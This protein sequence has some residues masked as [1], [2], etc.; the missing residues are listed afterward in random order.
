M[1]SSG[2]MFTFC[3]AK[4]D[5][6]HPLRTRVCVSSQ[7]STVPDSA[8]RTTLH[9][10]QSSQT[11][12][13]SEATLV[14]TTDL[15]RENLKRWDSLH[16]PMT[17]SAT[18]T[19]KT[20]SSIATKD[21]DHKLEGW[22]ILINTGSIPEDLEKHIKNVVKKPG[23]D[24][25]ASAKQLGQLAE[26]LRNA[27]ESTVKT[28]LTGELLFKPE[29]QGGEKNI[30]VIEDVGFDRVWL[31]LAPGPNTEKQY[32]KL[33]QP[34]PDSAVGYIRV[35]AAENSRKQLSHPFSRDQERAFAGYS[36][37]RSKDNILFL[38]LT[39][40]TSYLIQRDVLFPFLTAQWKCQSGEGHYRAAQQAARDGATI[41]RNLDC[42]FTDANYPA[43]V[44]DTAHFSLTTDSDSVKLWVH[45]IDKD[46]AAAPLYRMRCIK[47]A[48]LQMH[49]DD[50]I[51]M[52][53]MRMMLLNILE[54]ANGERLDRIKDAITKLSSD[55]PARVGRTSTRV[56]QLSTGSPLKRAVSAQHV[57]NSSDVMDQDVIENSP[58][59]NAQ[60]SSTTSRSPSQKSKRQK[61]TK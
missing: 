22:N 46:S 2:T 16:P 39:Q 35:T 42:F 8:L 53:D 1:T 45:W 27:S 43:T 34:R 3:P 29:A 57:G 7:K 9:P 51:G 50:D 13:D 60:T 10:S 14:V 24:T 15:T 32:G 37:F 25:T 19:E 48:F 59:L 41:S 61:I 26:T 20:Q 49:D 11:S 40:F 56:S 21:T 28:T 31:P 12:G 17:G 18:A 54:Y 58:D 5:T 52:K 33:E 4:E 6:A 55:P 23:K 38:L 36:S 47:Q 44:V 30:M